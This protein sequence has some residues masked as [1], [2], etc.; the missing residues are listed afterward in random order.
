MNFSN[1]KEW[2][3]PRGNVVQLAIDGKIAW[4]KVMGVPIS[5]LAV[6]SSVFMNVNGVR[7][8]FLVV[9]Q[10][11]PSSSY[12][13]SCDGTW[14]L[15]KDVYV[16]GTWSDP[17]YDEYAN[18]STSRVHEY[19]NGTFYNLFSSNL[20]NTIKQVKIPYSKYSTGYNGS[21]G[22]STKIF[23]L[24]YVEVGFT[25]EYDNEFG[26]YHVHAKGDGSVLSCFNGTNQE[27]RIA[28]LNGK[29][30]TWWLRTPCIDNYQGE[31]DDENLNHQAAFA[32]SPY[33]Y[34]GNTI[35]VS[36]DYQGFYGIRPALIL[37]SETLVDGSGNV[38]A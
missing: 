32:V 3:T 35:N 37:P 26:V 28:Y 27:K 11:L 1:L 34:T 30:V 10:G 8:E 16:N 20:K 33:G 22:L 21:N 19:L 7:T 14:L 9:H 36:S 25:I 15:M 12:D 13:A 38:I 6:G 17:S 24:S 31:D 4:K 18:Y 29:S 5:T 2:E 23:L